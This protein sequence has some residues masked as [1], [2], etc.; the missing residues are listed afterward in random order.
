[1]G[2]WRRGHSFFT[3]PLCALA[4]TH[5]CKGVRA[6]RAL[7]TNGVCLSRSTNTP[8]LSP[9]V[10]NHKLGRTKHAS[11]QH[12]SSPGH[13]SSDGKQ[14]RVRDG[15]GGGSDIGIDIRNNAIM[16]VWDMFLQRG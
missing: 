14:I 15:N 5:C 16:R 8:P 11:V 12:P 1:M 3:V 10:T 9:D 2:S 4:C 13:S 6:L 7:T